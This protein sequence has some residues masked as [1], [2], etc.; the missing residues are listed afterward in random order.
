MPSSNSLVKQDCA[1]ARRRTGSIKG[2]H[3]ALCQGDAMG[4]VISSIYREDGRLP[5]PPPGYK[6]FTTTGF[7]LDEDYLKRTPS[8]L[9]PLQTQKNSFRPVDRP[10]RD[11]T[12]PA[13]SRAVAAK[14]IPF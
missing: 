10:N 7:T 1:S 6:R 4:Q 9:S 2:A 3:Y 12:E 13:P 8:N 14:E 5:N 11:F